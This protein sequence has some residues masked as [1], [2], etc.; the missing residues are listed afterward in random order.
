MDF[1]PILDSLPNRLLDAVIQNLV[2]FLLLGV[3]LFLGLRAWIVGLSGRFFEWLRQRISGADRTLERVRSR[4][5]RER[6][7]TMPV[8][9]GGLWVAEPIHKPA[10]YGP[11][12]ADA[13]ILAIG[14]LKGGVGKTTLTANLGA[15]LARD[16]QKPVL[17]IDL[18]YQG[19][20]SSMAVEGLAW[21]PAPGHNA[22]ATHLVSGDITGRELSGAYFKPAA[23][24]NRLHVVPAWYDLG[25]ADNRLLVEWLI[26]DPAIPEEDRRYWL[27]RTLHDRAVLD[28]YCVIL[29]DCPPR[30]TMSH[31][32]G[33]CAASHL[34]IPTIMDAA[35]SEAV[36]SYIQ[37]AERLRTT[38]CPF[39]KP[40]GIVGVKWRKNYTAHQAA[41]GQLRALLP[42]V[43]SGAWTLAPREAYLPDRTAFNREGIA[44]LDPKAD[45]SVVEPVRA[46]AKWVKGRMDLGEPH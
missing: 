15:V 16:L 21:K 35:S 45:A 18:D 29:I 41:E 8:E 43:A 9:G 26:A 10:G 19:S 1:A 7:G 40:A 46:L 36:L 20:L 6:G 44:V 38:V 5:A 3:A 27:A 12:I 2:Y 33:L 23:L 4:V 17:M 22:F 32:Q 24:E 31:V 11:T 30:L 42:E 13:R 37:E 28:M 14:N 34:L 25:I 39:L